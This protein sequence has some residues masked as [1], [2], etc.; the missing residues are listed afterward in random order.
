MVGI[1]LGRISCELVRP[2]QRFLLDPRQHV[3]RGEG[4][5]HVLEHDAIDLGMVSDHAS[6]YR[7][8][9]VL[10]RSAPVRAGVDLHHRAATLAAAQDTAEKR[11]R[12][13]T[14]AFTATRAP[15][16][17]HA[18]TYCLPRLVIENAKLRPRGRLPFA[19]RPDEPFAPS[20]IGILDPLRAVP[21]VPPDVELVVQHARA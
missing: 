9:A 17:G 7:G 16:R 3:R 6:A 2:A 4:A 10:V 11:R 18:L 13:A 1:E 12:H 5:A 14:A 8:P 21:Y 15:G 20:R 19:F